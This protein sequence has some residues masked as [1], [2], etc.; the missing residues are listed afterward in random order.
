M[1]VD[2]AAA[3]M[4]QIDH[5][6]GQGFKRIV[7]RAD[8]LEAKQ[9]TP[10]FIFP[11]EYAFNGAKTF[12]ENIGIEDGLASGLC[13]LPATR[14]GIDI[15]GHAA[16]ENSFAVGLTIVGTV[17]AD[18]AAVQG[19]ADC[20]GDASDLRQGVTQ[21]RRFVAVTWCRHERSDHIAVSIAESDDLVALDLLMT[22]KAKIV[23][24]FF[25]RGRRAVAMDDVG[26][27]QMRCMQCRDRTAEN[28]IKAAMRMP[29]PEHPVNARVMNFWE[30]VLSF[31]D[32]QFFP[33]AAHVQQPQDIVENG[34]QTQIWGRATSAND[35][36]RQDKLRELR[37]IQI[38]RNPLPVLALCHIVRQSN[39]ILAQ[40][41]HVGENLS[42]A[43]LS[44][45]S[46]TLEKPATSR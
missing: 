9:Q 30:T 37:E 21:Q 41:S 28:Q 17:Q 12:F 33:L 3:E 25:R 18:N 5:R 42:W 8:E 27:E 36:M 7:Q 24:A 14:I 16:I 22:A 39:R 10:E 6:V 31:F 19:E 29:V 4:P 45:N 34:M 15:W 26:I 44:N 13:F 23:T 46:G 2:L 43:C 35:Q 11:G 32:R 1:I 40:I 20:A 38:R